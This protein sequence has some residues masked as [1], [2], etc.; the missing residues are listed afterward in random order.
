MKKTFLILGISMLALGSVSSCGK[1]G[2]TDANADNYDA[3]AKKD[4]ESCTYTASLVFYYSQ[5]TYLNDMLSPGHTNL[6]YFVESESVGTFPADNAWVS[7]S[8]PDC[9]SSGV[10]QVDISLSKQSKKLLSYEVKD[11]DDGTSLYTGSV[12]VDGGA[13][14]AIKLQ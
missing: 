2:C 9:N 12:N 7:A 14:T 6:E 5:T 3:S 10:F 8:A 4:D 11:A 13:C 1:K